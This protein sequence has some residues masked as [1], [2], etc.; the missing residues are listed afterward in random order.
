MTDEFNKKWLRGSIFQYLTYVLIIVVILIGDTLIIRILAA[1]VLYLLLFLILIQD[2]K[3]I[4][5]LE[6]MGDKK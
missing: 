4:K 3:I 5:K 2:Y 1:I 6:E